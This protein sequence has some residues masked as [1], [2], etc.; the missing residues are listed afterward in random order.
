MY[1]DVLEDNYIDAPHS[2]GVHLVCNLFWQSTLCDVYCPWLPD[3]WHQLLL[4]WIKYILHRLLK[5]QN[6]RNVKDQLD[7]QLTSLP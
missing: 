6:T 1:S 3:E 7:N 2:L 5:Y 4:D